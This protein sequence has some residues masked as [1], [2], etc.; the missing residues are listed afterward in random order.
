MFD[1]ENLDIV[2]E[3]ELGLK[4]FVTN[5][6]GGAY[7]SVDKDESII[8]GSPT[9]RLER[10]HVEVVDRVAE[11]VQDYSKEIPGLAP[12]VEVDDPMFQDAVVDY[13]GRV[14]FMVTGGRVGYYDVESDRVEMTDLAQELQNSMVVDDRGGYLVTYEPNFPIFGR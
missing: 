14:W 9:N 4:P 11:F 3:R 2:A 7:F 1:N 5:A 13:E 12:A 8:I 6:T 10:Y